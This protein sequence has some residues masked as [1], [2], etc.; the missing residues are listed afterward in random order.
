[1]Q[2]ALLGHTRKVLTCNKH[3]QDNG[4]YL[5]C[6]RVVRVRAGKKGVV[7]KVDVRDAT[8]MSAITPRENN[9]EVLTQPTLHRQH[10]FVLLLC[11]YEGY[12]VQ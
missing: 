12:S 5:A 11:Y 3:T 10:E 9:S 1:M 2:H 7:G 8:W 4:C 6:C